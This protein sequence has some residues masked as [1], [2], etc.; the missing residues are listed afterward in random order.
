MVPALA[1]LDALGACVRELSSACGTTVQLDIEEC[2]LELDKQV[3]DDAFAPLAQWLGSRLQSGFDRPEQRLAEG[4]PGQGRV[5]L[6]A[7]ALGGQCLVLEIDDDGRGVE[8]APELAL[9]DSGKLQS[10]L[11]VV[12][13]SVEWTGAPAAVNR[14]RVTLPITRALMLTLL[15]SVRGRTLALPLS[16]IQEVSRRTLRGSEGDDRIELHGE[17]MPL[18][19]LGQWLSLP[20]VPNPP[21][22]R[23]V[24]TVRHGSRRV[25]LLV[26]RAIGQQSLL[27][28]PLGASLRGVRAV[29]GA[30]DVG[31]GRLALVLDPSVLFDDARTLDEPRRLETSRSE[32]GTS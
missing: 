12:G 27:V 2:S 23:H 6:R 24:V 20:L 4:K 29:T 9:A 14:L 21:P 1:L 8:S 17:H 32:R 10:Q 30:A 3:A 31:D 25:A 13:A 28:K 19:D 22:A 11:R 5:A 7:R 16:S 18:V 26:E 15:V